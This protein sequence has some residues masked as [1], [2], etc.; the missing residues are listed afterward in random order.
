[1]RDVAWYWHK[2]WG[3]R[4]RNAKKKNKDGSWCE[5]HQSLDKNGDV[6]RI[7]FCDDCLTALFY[8]YFYY[9]NLFR[10]TIMWFSEQQKWKL[11]KPPKQKQLT[12]CITACAWN[13]FSNSVFFVKLW[14]RGLLSGSHGNNC[15]RTEE[16]RCLRSSLGTQWIFPE[17]YAHHALICV[18]QINQQMSPHHM[19]YRVIQGWIK[20]HRNLQTGPR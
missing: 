5:H 11:W 1:M 7:I 8:Y 19:L 15:H 9:L 20:C 14:I 4:G 16:L 17:V 2:C 3:S 12:L 6:S 10:I 18:L 13:V